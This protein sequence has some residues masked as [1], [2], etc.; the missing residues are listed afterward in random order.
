MSDNKKLNDLVKDTKNFPWPDVATQVKYDKWRLYH[1]YHE[2]FQR[3]L[4]G[5]VSKSDM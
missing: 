5:S 1:W 2:T 3:M 4:T